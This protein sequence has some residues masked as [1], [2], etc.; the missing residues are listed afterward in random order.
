MSFIQRG[1][2][3]SIEYDLPTFE[4]ADQPVP[5]SLSFLRLRWVLGRDPVPNTIQVLDDVT[6][7]AS[8][9]QPYSVDHPIAMDPATDPPVRTITVGQEDLEYWEHGWLEVHLPH[10]PAQPG[11]AEWEPA[12]PWG[13]EDEDGPGELPLPLLRR[14][15]APRARRE[16]APGDGARHGA[17]VRDGSRFHRDGRPV[18]AVARLDDRRPDLEVRRVRIVVRRDAQGPLRILSLAA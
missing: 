7:P 2:T 5:S 8:A 14:G 17:A 13:Y 16:P 15:A 4:E 10:A 18:A 9:Q 12:A 11:W 6:D 3:T 1:G